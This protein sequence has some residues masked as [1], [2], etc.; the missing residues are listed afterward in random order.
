LIM[1]IQKIRQMLNAHLPFPEFD[2]KA[3]VHH[4]NFGQ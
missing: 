2:G 1:V 4:T 3:R